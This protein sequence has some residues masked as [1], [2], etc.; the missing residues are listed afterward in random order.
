MTTFKYITL[1]L[2]AVL[3]ISC[4][5]NVPVQTETPATKLVPVEIVIGAPAS[6]VNGPATRTT[7]DGTKITWAPN[8]TMIVAK[9][10]ENATQY[11]LV[12]EKG[13]NPAVFTGELPEGFKEGRA[14]YP[15]SMISSIPKTTNFK[16][17]LKT[18]QIGIK[19][20]Y[21]PENFVLYCN[22]ED[23]NEG[24]NMK[25]ASGLVK[26]TIAGDDITSV[27]LTSNTTFITQNDLNFNLTNGN[28]SA[29][30]GSKG[31]SITLV[32]E[33]GKT[34]FEKGD[35]CIA[36]IGK[37]GDGRPLEGGINIK[38]IKSDNSEWEKTSANPISIK[39]GESIPLDVT[40]ND[41]TMTVPPHEGPAGK[42]VKVAIVGGAT[43][44]LTKVEDG[45]FEGTVSVPATGEFKLLLDNAE[46]GFVAHS[47]AG[48]LGECNNVNSALPYEY[49]S[50]IEG[51]TR[52]YNVRKALGSIETIEKGACNFWINN[53]EAISMYVN[54]DVQKLHYYF[55]KVE[56]PDPNVVIDETFDLLVYGGDYLA[57]C[58]GWNPPAEDP[59]GAST[60]GNAAYTT[61]A[62][63]GATYDGTTAKTVPIEMIKAWEVEGWCDPKSIGYRPQGIQFGAN[64]ANKPTALSTP[65]FS[66]LAG[67][68]DVKIEM[69]LARFAENSTQD[70]Y[71]EVLGGGQ[72]TSGSFTADYVKYGEGPQTD[73]FDNGK[74]PANCYV[75]GDCDCFSHTKDW[76]GAG[77]ANNSVNKP[78]THFTIQVSGATPDTQL[79]LHSNGVDKARYVIYKFKVTKA[80]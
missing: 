54:V 49:T 29:G 7:S 6:V 21:D 38:Y 73:V 26:F 51:C 5:K 68:T 59:W 17:N 75:L 67:T 80:N 78:V 32:P 39:Q 30:S 58:K 77:S 9:N 65:K 25:L 63:N 22:F 40:E 56:T 36:L 14:F 52:K 33:E 60:G 74:L 47:G 27:V 55:K 34:T 35:Y 18:A 62:F 61:P 4:S 72:I 10:E 57:P 76:S 1:G 41:C 2:A 48:G 24:F 37:S 16:I 66:A 70:L 69:D 23:I 20:A 44:T 71:I 45:I 79:K 31:N 46:Y 3:A 43:T 53:T 15:A 8:D 19:D 50:V 11:K 64:G 13:G 42:S 28:I 12:T